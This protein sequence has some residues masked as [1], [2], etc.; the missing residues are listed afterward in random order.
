MQ[1]QQ[2]QTARAFS[3]PPASILV[4][5]VGVALIGLVGPVYLLVLTGGKI[6]GLQLLDLAHTVWPLLMS[7]GCLASLVAAVLYWRCRKSGVYLQM[8]SLVILAPANILIAGLAIGFTLIVSSLA[9]L[10]AMA[11]VL[12]GWV[13][14][15][16]LIA[17]LGLAFASFFCQRMGP[18]IGQYGTECVPMSDCYGPLLAGGFPL[19][20]YVDQPGHTFEYTLDQWDEFR[21]APF[22][23]DTCFFIAAAFGCV[24]LVRHYR[25][26]QAD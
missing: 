8:L 13:F 23:L 14:P 18:G 7:V 5:S 19:Q 9:I 6:T 2:P 22:I 26:S 24:K 12:K 15:A 25:P 4:S 16:I 10:A 20:Y 1:K 17:G 21:L 3:R 11:V